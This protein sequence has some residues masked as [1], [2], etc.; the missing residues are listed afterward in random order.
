MPGE[1][2]CRPSPFALRLQRGGLHGLSAPGAEQACQAESY[3]GVPAGKVAALCTHWLSH[4][5]QETATRLSSARVADFACRN[6]VTLI[7]VFL[8]AEPRLA[9]LHTTSVTSLA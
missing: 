2:R 4:H 9:A 6:A 8:Q 3:H 1:R 5:S 7:T